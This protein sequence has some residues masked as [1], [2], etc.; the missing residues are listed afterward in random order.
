MNN[1]KTLTAAIAFA[2]FGIGAPAAMAQAGGTAPAQQ[3]EQGQPAAAPISEENL[4]KFVE[5]DAD[6]AELRDEFSEKLSKAE[7]QEEA[8]KLQLEAQEKMVEAVQDSDL[9]VPTYNEIATRM[10][11]DPELQQRAQSLK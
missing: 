2:T 4:K 6:V 8:Q 3:Y 11:T 7:D 1:L 10:Q 5:A 9:D